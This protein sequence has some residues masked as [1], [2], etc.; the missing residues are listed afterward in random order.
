[1]NQLLQNIQK[2]YGVKLGKHD[3]EKNR[4]FN[5]GI[6]ILKVTQEYIEEVEKAEL[7][8]EQFFIDFLDSLYETINKYGAD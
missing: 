6:F 7:T 8:N 1:M 3:T 2:A 5:K 4:L